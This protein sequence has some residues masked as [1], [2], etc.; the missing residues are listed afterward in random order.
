M[1]SLTETREFNT[2]MCHNCITSIFPF[3]H[4]ENN[5]LFL[6]AASHQLFSIGSNIFFPLDISPTH[7]PFDMSDIDPDAQ[8]YNELPCFQNVQNCTYYKEFTFQEK[9]KQKTISDSSLS[10]V[11]FNIRSVRQ[12]LSSAELFL[13]NLGFR[14]TVIALTETWLQDSNC[15]LYS[16]NG[17]NIECKNRVDKMGGGVA[18]LIKSEVNYVVRKDYSVFVDGFESL[19]IE[20][21]KS[22]TSNN[23]AVVIGVIYRPPGGAIEDFNSK[24]VDIA[25]KLKLEDKLIY[26]AGDFNINLLNADSHQPTSDFLDVM[27]SASFFPLI[28]RPT[29]VTSQSATLIDNIFTNDILNMSHFN[30]IFVSDITDHY[31][32]FSINSGIIQKS[33]ASLIKRRDINTG[34]IRTFEDSLSSTNWDM[35]L[36]NDDAETSFKL[37][38]ETFTR[39]YNECFPLKYSKIGYTNRKPWLTDGLKLAIKTKNKLFQVMRKNPTP[40]NTQNYKT[41]KFFLTKL[42]RKQ[43]R[44]YFNSLLEKYKSN[45]KKTW[46]VIKSVINKHKTKNAMEMSIRVN[47]SIIEDG[48]TI[49]ENFNKCYVNVGPNLSRL[50]PKT[51]TNPAD[52]IPNN[53]NT[54]FISEA[55]EAEVS[56]IIR[57]MRDSSAGPDGISSKILKQ[58]LSLIVKPLVHTVNLSLNQG[59]FPNP[60]KI[61]RVIPI[62]KSGDPMVMKNYRPVSVLNVL[63]KVFEKVMYNRL[64]DFLDAN[65]ILYKLQFG[66][67]RNHNTNIALSYL[68][69]KII[70]SLDR[71][72]VVIGTFID[73]SKAFDTVNHSILLAKLYKYGIR[74]CAHNWIKSYLEKR[75]QYVYCKDHESSMLEIICGVPQGSILGPLLFLIYINDI[76]KVSTSVMPLLYADDTNLFCSGKDT[77]EIIGTLNNELKLYMRWMHVNKL[78]VNVDKTKVIIFRKPKRQPSNQIDEIK[79]NGNIIE[80]VPSMKFLGVILDETLSW[81]AHINYIKNKIAKGI[82]VICKAK[83]FLYSSSLLSL[84]NSFIQPYL[85]YCIEGWGCTFTTYLEPLWRLQKRAVRLIKSLSYRQETHL[86]F[87]ELHI[88][89]IF[90]LYKYFTLI[91]MFKVKKGMVPAIFGEFFEY[92]DHQY[93]TRGTSLYRIPYCKTSFSQRSLRYLGAKLHNTFRDLEWNCSLHSFKRNIK[94]HLLEHK[95]N[96]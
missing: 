1:T 28:N 78:T 27:Y 55:T 36:N 29:R 92:T 77:S 37:F 60:L 16:V 87:K 69:D 75:L 80:K 58:T 7:D 79:L 86:A 23:R 89:N 40:I 53:T 15:D 52:C 25:S 3:N 5:D 68:L 65:N 82:G 43:E 66:F 71:G 70:S 14:F 2:N 85:I 6:S 72:E 33:E 45:L 24:L 34:S 88:L 50:I 54:I 59:Y 10:I 8:F 30:G 91:F 38:Y 19:F 83:R 20:I 46:N 39:K 64:F 63:S 49:A 48:A 31:P 93:E 84:Y 67:R 35:V 76:V 51:S 26:L 12:N 90:Q 61:A 22:L 74:G 41:Y 47:D 18:L 73:L 94:L 62:Y 11:H 13:Y 56:N 57:N 95:V 17:Y 44:D 81:L 96:R 32:I 21:P 9:C 42:L 4:I